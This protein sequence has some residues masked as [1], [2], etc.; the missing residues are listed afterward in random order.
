M[1]TT[2]KLIFALL[3]LVVF[4]AGM[5]WSY[6]KDNSSSKIHYPKPYK[7]LIFIILCFVLMFLFVKYR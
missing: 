5:A 1:F 6:K 2:G 7:L 3:F 4:V